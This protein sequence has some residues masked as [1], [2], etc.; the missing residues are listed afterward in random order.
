MPSR[1]MAI[2]WTVPAAASGRCPS[3]E[4]L[5]TLRQAK[6]DGGGYTR[7]LF[8]YAA[9]NLDAATWIGTDTEEGRERL[10]TAL[11]YLLRA[12]DQAEMRSLSEQ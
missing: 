2:T 9:A 11:D 1:L 3:S 12:I 4:I 8:G 5:A 6:Q 7:H 10:A